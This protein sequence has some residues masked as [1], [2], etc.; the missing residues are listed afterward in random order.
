M[1]LL[2]FELQL[3]AM[4]D[5]WLTKIYF[6]FTTIFDLNDLHWKKSH[7][8]LGQWFGSV[9]PHRMHCHCAMLGIIGK[10]E[11]S[12]FNTSLALDPSISSMPLNKVLRPLA[13]L[14]EQTS[15]NIIRIWISTI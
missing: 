5:K 2:T 9:R 10:A 14:S 6:E 4:M 8:E 15:Y 11:C 7:M 13:L 3:L 12:A 1:T